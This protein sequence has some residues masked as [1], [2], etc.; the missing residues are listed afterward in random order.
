M[1]RYALAS[2]GYAYGYKKRMK[3]KE[4]YLLDVQSLTDKS[5]Q[6]RKT[7][8]HCRTLM[9][10]KLSALNGTFGCYQLECPQTEIAC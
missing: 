2:H 4:H 5:S 1:T 9:K 10:I 8:K 6:Q 7:A 3:N